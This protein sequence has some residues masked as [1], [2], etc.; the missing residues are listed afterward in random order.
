MNP[1]EQFLSDIENF[2]AETGMKASAFG[3]SAIKDRNLVGD[4][5]KGRSPSLAVVGRVN[6]FMRSHKVDAA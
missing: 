2:L 1:A 3:W 6:E 4:L 5:R